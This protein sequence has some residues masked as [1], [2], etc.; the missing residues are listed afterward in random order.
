MSIAPF[1]S[2]TSAVVTHI[3]CGKPLVSTAMFRLIP[4]TFLPA[5]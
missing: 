2:V 5:S 4:D 1:L 3:A